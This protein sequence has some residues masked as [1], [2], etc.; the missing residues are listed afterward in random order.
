MPHLNIQQS[1][2]DQISQ[3]PLIIRQHPPT[4]KGSQIA[5]DS[6][7]DKHFALSEMYF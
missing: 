1:P 3:Q 4:V 2:P 6:D 7:H 5:E